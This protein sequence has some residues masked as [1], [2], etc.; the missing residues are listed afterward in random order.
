MKG[1]ALMEGAHYWSGDIA[2]AEGAIAA[3]CRFYGGYPITPSSEIAERMALRLPQVG[4]VFIQMED[5]IASMAAILGASWA[6]KKAM[7]A[8]SGPGFSLML[9]N[10]GLGVMMETPCVIVNVQRGAPSTGLPTMVGQSDMMQAK[11][12]SHGSYEIIALY[13]NSVQETF[14]LIIEAFNLA[15]R[16]RVPVVYL[17]DESI[18]HLFE[19]VTVPPEDE[20]EKRLVYRKR[21]NGGG[22]YLP[23]LVEDEDLVPPMAIA[24]E[25]ARMHITGLTHDERGYPSMTAEAQEK[26]VRRLNEKIRR[27]REKITMV[28][29]YMLEDADVAVVSFGITSRVAKR[30]VDIARGDGIKAGMLRL[31]TIWPFPE[32]VIRRLAESVK[33][34]VVAEINYGQIYYEVERCACPRKVLLV[35]KMGGAVH[36]PEEIVAGIK[37]VLRG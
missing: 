26:L 20:I 13:P 11:W 36:R 1:R 27:V 31:K 6:G 16:Y 25:G 8:T 22:A 17:M 4:G 23:Y 15:E 12:G 19:K 5:E 34:F 28:E 18:G 35:P 21:P 37:E 2:A 7:T 32:H 10:I 3:G 29:E 9:E 33:A 30:A 14:D 24:G